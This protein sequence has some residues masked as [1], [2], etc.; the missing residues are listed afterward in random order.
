MYRSGMAGRDTIS[1][2][3]R[4]LH[5]RRNPV[6]SSSWPVFL[7]VVCLPL[8]GCAPPATPYPRS[9]ISERPAERIAAV[10]H[11]AEIGDESVIAILV[12]RLEDTDEA[13]RFFAIIA[14]EKM[15]GERFGYQYYDSEVERARAV[16]RWRRYLQER[17]PV[18]SQ[19]EGGAAL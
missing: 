11:A 12:Q 14:L 5:M 7:A 1:A 13:V 2:G 19:P 17:Y 10:K 4:Y 15:T 8:I 3:A 9:L 16:T 18:A 6:R